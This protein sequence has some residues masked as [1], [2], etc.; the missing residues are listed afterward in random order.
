MTELKARYAMAR[1]LV[2]PIPEA[3]TGRGNVR[4]WSKRSN[5]FSESI[6]LTSTTTTVNQVETLE[7]VYPDSSHQSP[8]KSLKDEVFVPVRPASVVNEMPGSLLDNSHK[9]R[10]LILPAHP[11]IGDVLLQTRRQ[12]TRAVNQTLQLLFNNEYLGLIAYTQCIIPVMYIAYMAVLQTL[13]NRIYYPEAR[14]VVDLGLFADRMLVI[15]LLAV[16]Q[17]ISLLILHKLWQLA[18]RLCWR[19][20]HVR[21]DISGAV[22]LTAD[23]QKTKSAVGTLSEPEDEDELVVTMQRAGFLK[24]HRPEFTMS[25]HTQQE[26]TAGMGDWGQ[27]MINAMREVLYPKP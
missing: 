16:F 11:V 26:L 17:F 23:R 25:P 21:K 12:N 3:T 19:P 20:T 6:W 5:R 24:L 27:V 1:M 7:D 10:S 2:R 13:S 8:H 9:L 4:G 22:V 14:N 18:S 15:G